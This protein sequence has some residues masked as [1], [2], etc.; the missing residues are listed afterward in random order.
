[1]Y[2]RRGGAADA[3]GGDERAREGH[4]AAVLQLCKGRGE[5]EEEEP[6]RGN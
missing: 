6:P 2:L 5:E 3:G 1:M 4:D